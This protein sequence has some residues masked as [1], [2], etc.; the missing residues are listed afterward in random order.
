MGHPLYLWERFFKTLSNTSR[1]W[2]LLDTSFLF[3][4]WNRT[5]IDE[6]YNWRHRETN[7]SLLTTARMI[8]YSGY[9]WNL[10]QEYTTYAFRAQI[11]DFCGANR[12]A[13]YGTSTMHRRA[14]LI[15]VLSNE[16][17]PDSK[18]RAASKRNERVRATLKF[19]TKKYLSNVRK[20]TYDGQIVIL[21]F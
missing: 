20:K 16:T 5:L 17:C 7:F 14:C 15:S 18:T 19:E 12:K 9:W 10:L 11:V 21:Q 3:N 13:L 4:Y 1:V 8:S 2:Y 6:A